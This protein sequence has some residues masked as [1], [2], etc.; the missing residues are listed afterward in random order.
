MV[1]VV[2]ET[3]SKT[4]SGCVKLDSAESYILYVIFLYLRTYDK[5]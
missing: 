4:S 2:G 3:H 1:V 5:V